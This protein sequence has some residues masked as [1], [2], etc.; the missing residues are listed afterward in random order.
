MP[1]SPPNP[2]AHPIAAKRSGVSEELEPQ[3]IIKEI[4]II[5][6]DL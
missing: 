5:Q 2:P 4:G 1:Y 3:E 6:Q